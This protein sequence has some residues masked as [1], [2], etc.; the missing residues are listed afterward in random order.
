MPNRNSLYVT[1]ALIDGTTCE[2]VTTYKSREG[3]F[4]TGTATDE[5]G[6]KF[7]IRGEITEIFEQERYPGF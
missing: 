1:Q 5:N 4:T 3:D 2:I 7:L 6:N